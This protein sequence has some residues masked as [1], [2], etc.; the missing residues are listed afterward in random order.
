M[1]Q[2]AVVKTGTRNKKKNRPIP[3]MA[4]EKVLMIVTT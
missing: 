1:L 4:E 2:K 3:E